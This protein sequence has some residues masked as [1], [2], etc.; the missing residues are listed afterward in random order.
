LGSNANFAT[1]FFS[2]RFRSFAANGQT[3]PS[4]A[5]VPAQL[6]SVSDGRR[7]SADP[8]R[9]QL[10]IASP[11]PHLEVQLKSKVLT[12]NTTFRRPIT[13]F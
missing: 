2:A 5:A 10:K 12:E 9:F 11:C 6:E 8:A 13:C 7:K 3:A 4:A 1:E